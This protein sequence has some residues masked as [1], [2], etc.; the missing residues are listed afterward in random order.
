MNYTEV[1]TIK[2]PSRKLEERLRWVGVQKYLR[3]EKLRTK[4]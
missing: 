4:Y 2:R 1:I 3:L